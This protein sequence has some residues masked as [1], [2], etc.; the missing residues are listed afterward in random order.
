MI[1]KREE[2]NMSLLELRGIGKIYV[3]E[4]S[5]AVGIRGVDLN[6]DIGEF[7]AV[8]GKSGSGKTTLLNC[9]S[10]MDSYE[11]GELYINGEPTSHYTQRD[12]EE[13]RQ[14]YISF[15][16]QD[17]N[18]IDS[19]T[20]LQNVELALTHIESHAERRR[21]ALELID[22]VGMT[23][24][25]NSKGSK[26]SG[27][28]KQ[29]TVIARALAK[30]SPIILADEPTGNLDSKTSEEIVELLSEISKDKLVIVVT[31][32]FSQFE[33]V[34]TREVRI[35]DG[36]VER[37][38]V[39]KQTEVGEYVPKPEI[40][41]RRRDI[42]LGIELG[43]HK[44]FAAPK[45]SVFMCIIML[46]AMLGSFFI[47]ALYMA[48]TG[49]DMTSSLFT[50]REGR[51]VIS[52]EAGGAISD[53]ELAALKKDLSADSYMQYDYL[54]DKQTNI[55]YYGAGGMYYGAGLKFA[56]I[57]GELPS[58]GRAPSAEGEC[59]LMLPIVW[60]L[61][62]G[63]D[64]LELDSIELYGIFNL[65]VVGVKYYYDNTKPYS[66]V[67]L[68]RE[69]FDTLTRAMIFDGAYV[70]LKSNNAD[71]T[72]LGNIC[73][74]Y[75]LKKGEFYVISPDSFASNM[76]KR[77]NVSL[78]AETGKDDASFEANITE[79]GWVFREDLRRDKVSSEFAYY[80]DALVVSA[81][82]AREM[83]YDLY[84]KDYTQASLFF[85]SDN[86]ARE[87]KE[88]LDSKGYVGIVSDERYDSGIEAVLDFIQQ[89]I[90]I[91]MWVVCIIFLGLFLSLCL[92][93]AFAASNSDLA[94]LR[95]MGISTAIVKISM[96]VRTCIAAIPSLIALAVIAPA[97]YLNPLTNQFIP[98]AHAYHYAIIIIG[99]VL[100]SFIVAYRCNKRIFKG[101]VIKNL[102]GGDKV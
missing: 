10:G 26:L 33:S 63:K 20:V 41:R 7:V 16:F 24:H 28:Q 83:S 47:T 19:F 68:T 81:D 94:I 36:S 53:S 71:A 38:E 59:M 23:Q 27:G 91:V 8:T 62:Y 50:Y 61:V 18:I 77:G 86:G 15:V 54:L 22:R 79:K 11:E 88:L 32:S 46:V 57:D 17:Y 66:H 5:V 78:V 69:G 39:M 55:S 9:I 72:S 3:S 93:R 85:D 65:K 67:L 6:F 35:F 90:C 73:V 37:D 80:D 100:L 92:R 74:D 12:W 13:Y 76:I 64:E 25:K 60:Q 43:R 40:S 29:R 49:Y 31:H 52:K 84:C 82:I 97:I 48:D 45:L 42:S 1:T 14:K 58:V 98:F 87:A 4:N 99:M 95:S 51:L 44:F 101:S 89:V 102:K 56:P 75:S 21:R 2:R 30:D 34:A 96:Y 70:T